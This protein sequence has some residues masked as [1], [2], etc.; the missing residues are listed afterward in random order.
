[1]LHRDACV[2]GFEE[3]MKIV[4]RNKVEGQKQ[5]FKHGEAGCVQEVVKSILPGIDAVK[6]RRVGEAGR[7]AVEKYV[8]I[9]LAVGLPAK[10]GLSPL[11][12]GGSLEMFK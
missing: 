3:C 6:G 4:Q 12:N 1:M 10:R 7:E 8:W 5:R 2:L 9:T 11:G